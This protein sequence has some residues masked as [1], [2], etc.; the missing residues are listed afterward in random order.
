VAR[1]APWVKDCLYPALNPLVI[2]G[3]FTALII[4]GLRVPHSGE[5]RTGRVVLHTENGITSNL[6][7]LEAECSSRRLSFRL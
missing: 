5:G 6:E 2:L 7:Y 1:D 4:L 3:L